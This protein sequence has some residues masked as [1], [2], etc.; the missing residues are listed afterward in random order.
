MA[1]RIKAEHRLLLAQPVDIYGAAAISRAAINSAFAKSKARRPPFDP[2]AWAAIWT[3]V[4]IRRRAPNFHV[5]LA[6][7]RLALECKHGPV[8]RIREIYAAAEKRRHADPL[9]KELLDNALMQLSG[10]LI[11]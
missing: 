7:A 6:C 3:N 10:S 1:K 9:F 4:E 8:E 11:K 5:K 2:G